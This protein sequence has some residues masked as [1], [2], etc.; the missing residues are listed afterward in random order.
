[1]SLSFQLE[2][3][4]AIL[5]TVVLCGIIGVNRERLDHP[6][7]LRTHILVGV[8]ACVFTL[9][10]LNAFPS[11]DKSRVAAQIVSGIGFLG[12]GS[13]LKERG[14]IKGLTTA[15]SLWATAAVGMTMGTGAWFLAITLTLII[16]MVLEVLRKF[17]L[18]PL[19]PK[20]PPGHVS[21]DD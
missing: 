3:S 4:L 11:S 20:E 19:D 9:L 2:S 15:A 16:W 6:A 8:G 7:G 14:H 13:I 17:T 5:I 21:T 1:M 18:P 12:A 10:S